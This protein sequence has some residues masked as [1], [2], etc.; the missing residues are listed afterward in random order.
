MS[1]VIEEMKTEWRLRYNR[2]LTPSELA[3]EFALMPMETRIAHLKRVNAPEA[4]NVR[5]TADRLAMERALRRTHDTLQK[6]GR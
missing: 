1:D 2:D 4:M 6:V 5:E 3:N